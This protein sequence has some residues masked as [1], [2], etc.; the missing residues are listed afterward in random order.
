MATLLIRGKN[1]YNV[2]SPLL[3]VDGF[4][5]DFQQLALF[6]IESV[7][8]LKDAAAL[9]L[10]GQKGANGAILVTT[11]RGVEGKTRITFN[12]YG[13]VQQP[14]KMPGLLNSF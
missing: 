14:Q 6:E 13:G 11:K 9:A 10:Y 7:S 3:L 1:S 4:E 8:I 2:N 5:T 12:L